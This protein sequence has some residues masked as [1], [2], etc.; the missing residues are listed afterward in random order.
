MRS[1]VLHVGIH[2]TASTRPHPQARIHKTE[3]TYIQ[4]RLKR[5]QIVLRQPPSLPGIMGFLIIVEKTLN[6]PD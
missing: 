5:N 2:K 4:H 3:S 1:L 6:D